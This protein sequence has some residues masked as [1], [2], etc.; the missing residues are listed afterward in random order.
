MDNNKKHNSCSKCLEHVLKIQDNFD[1]SAWE[2]VGN[3]LPQCSP[4]KDA[5]R[6]RSYQ[7]L[8]NR[9]NVKGD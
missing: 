4:C 8:G 5:L 2:T 1:P 3:G 9:K 6:Q 7:Y